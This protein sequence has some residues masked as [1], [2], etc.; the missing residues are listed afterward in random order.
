MYR[1]TK[2]SPL[3]FRSLA[4]FI[5]TWLTILVLA[6]CGEQDKAA[7]IGVYIDNAI[8]IPR[9]DGLKEGLKGLGYVE[10]RNIRFQVLNGV[11]TL[12]EQAKN[13]ALRE[14]IDKNYQIYWTTN[15]T[16]AE[17]LKQAGLVK[18][19]LVVSGFSDPVA[20]GLV[21]SL[22]RPGANMTGV[23]SINTELTTKRLNW[24]LKF[25]PTIRSVYLI[26]DSKSSSQTSY[27]AAIRAEA[28]RLGV[29]LI[30]KTASSKPESK[31]LLVNLKA[32]EAQAILTVGI[33]PLTQTLDETELKAV[34][35]R[36]KLVLIGGDRTHLELGA[37]LT[38][39]SSYNATGQQSS[40]LW[41]RF[42]GEQTQALYQLLLRIKL[43]FY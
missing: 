14:F 12:Q 9:F 33:S 6:A 13:P 19:P 27:L 8:Q 35:E 3:I 43:S 42:Y 32:S 25:D 16:A 36:E 5:I 31:S 30:E 7:E 15:G 24:L 37:L 23:D 21:Q 22:D 29:K 17:L 38:Y 39:G 41:T 34:I 2:L 28:G 1:S 4:L 18:Q 10:G 40:F 26:Y 20:R 11:G